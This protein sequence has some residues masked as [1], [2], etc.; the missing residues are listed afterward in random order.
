[1][2]NKDTTIHR[3]LRSFAGGKIMVNIWVK[4][5]ENPFCGRINPATIPNEGVPFTPRDFVLVGDD[6][7]VSVDDIVAIRECGS[8]HSPVPAP[9][10]WP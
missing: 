5:R 4:G 2:K 10:R 8:A 6:V 1:M 3:L 9:N 7:W